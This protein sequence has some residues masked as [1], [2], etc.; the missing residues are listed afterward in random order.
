MVS[1]VFWNV[2]EQDWSSDGCEVVNETANVVFCACSHLTTFGS[3]SVSSVCVCVCVCVCFMC[4]TMCVLCFLYVFVVF[5]CKFC[6]G[7]CVNLWFVY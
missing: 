4:N 5:M 3:L 2:T 7:Q 6:V 1:C